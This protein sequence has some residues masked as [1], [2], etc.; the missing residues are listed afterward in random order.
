MNEI[1][2]NAFALDI[3]TASGN[4][5]SEASALRSFFELL[6]AAIKA[7]Y[8]VGLSDSQ[9]PSDLVYKS[10]LDHIDHIVT[11][12]NL[13]KLLPNL[14]QLKL[15]QDEITSLLNSLDEV[16]KRCS[17]EP[18]D[19]QGAGSCSWTI[20][21]DQ[22]WI[23]PLDQESVLK[24]LDSYA[25]LSASLD[26]GFSFEWNYA[27]SGESNYYNLLAV[28]S[29]YDSA[30]PHRWL[31]LDEPD[32]AFHPEWKR[33]SIEWIIDA[34]KNNGAP[35]AS[36]QLWISTHS[37]IMLSDVPKEAAILLKLKQGKNAKL[38]K[39]RS[40][41]KTS[42]FAQQIYS[43]FND[44]FFMEEGIVGSYANVKLQEVYNEIL[45]I[46]RVVRKCK[47]RTKPLKL[48][49]NYSPHIHAVIALIDEPLLKAYIKERFE[50]CE[51]A[52]YR[53]PESKKKAKTIRRSG[54]NA[55]DSNK[56]RS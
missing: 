55:D 9:V 22:K 34:C 2:R 39:T 49:Q 3:K 28:L 30:R 13:D 42:P 10:V 25:A 51:A 40:D 23:S 33:R 56:P 21:L 6:K 54:D 4:D 47:T 12:D 29:A 52:V 20:K 37:P 31:F 5:S 44:S 19:I 36:S 38:C 26:P 24:L 15:I 8:D 14:S 43:L 16:L 50:R 27:S 7:M 18:M 32:N 17:W 1:A 46:E 48:L 53:L 45:E 11:Y 41:N 35:N